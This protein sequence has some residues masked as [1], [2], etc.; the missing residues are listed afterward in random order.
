MYG[1]G[2]CSIKSLWIKAVKH[3]KSNGNTVKGNWANIS[4]LERMKHICGIQLKL[5][6]FLSSNNVTI[7]IPSSNIS[8][9]DEKQGFEFGITFKDPD[10]DLNITKPGH[11]LGAGLARGQWTKTPNPT[12]E[13]DQFMTYLRDN[14]HP[15]NIGGKTVYAPLPS[16]K[17]KAGT[18][19]AINNRIGKNMVF[20]W[21]ANVYNYKE[22]SSSAGNQGESVFEVLSENRSLMYNF[23]GLI[24]T[25][26]DSDLKD[27]P[28]IMYPDLDEGIQIH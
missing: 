12:T 9:E 13:C 3:V 17:N 20:I 18:T 11:G 24:T 7:V 28:N 14:V 15:D 23:C 1:G 8:S 16:R 5:L 2:C 21:G 26:S 22:S 25:P 27:V 10:T 6:K 19:I 4:L